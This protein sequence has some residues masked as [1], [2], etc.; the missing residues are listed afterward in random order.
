[1]WADDENLASMF[2]GIELGLEENEFLFLT[3]DDEGNYYR[4]QSTEIAMIDSP[5]LQ[6]LDA[7][8]KLLK[9]MEEEES[10]ISTR[11]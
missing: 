3:D 2:H 6:V 10:G 8:E 7:M 9:E 1:M 4:F 5:K 11:K